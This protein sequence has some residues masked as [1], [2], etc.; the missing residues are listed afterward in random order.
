MCGFLVAQALNPIVDWMPFQVKNI[1]YLES[2]GV[3]KSVLEKLRKSKERYYNKDQFDDNLKNIITKSDF[4]KYGE[5]IQ[6]VS[7]DLSANRLNR[8]IAWDKTGTQLRELLFQNDILKVSFIVSREYQ[9]SSTLT[10]YLNYP[11]WPHSIEKTERNIWSPIEKVKVSSSI[12]VCELYE[13]R[14]D[15][16][17]FYK[18]FNLPVQYLGEVET[19]RGSRLIRNL[20][21]YAINL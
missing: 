7:M 5:L 9:L 19:L 21:I 13:C 11:S 14:G 17:D 2:K 3:E 1:D 16:N 6:K 18:R 20:Q 8:V 10:F 15:L 12:F 4:E